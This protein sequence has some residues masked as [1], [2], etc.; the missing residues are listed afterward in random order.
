[1]NFQ[2][3]SEH[4]KV[5]SENQYMRVFLSDICLRTSC[6]SCQFKDIPRQSDLTIGDAWGIQ[7]HIPEMDDDRG[8]SAV[9]V[10]SEKGLAVERRSVG[11]MRATGGVGRTA[12]HYR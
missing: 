8:T 7:N 3:G 11:T 5:N 6:H 4:C 2:N 9:I 12:A 1:M 10:H